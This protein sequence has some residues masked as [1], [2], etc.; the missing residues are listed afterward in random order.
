MTGLAKSMTGYGKCESV[1][2]E[3]QIVVEIKSVNNRYL[4]V[5]VK[6]PR[7]M[8]FA[9]EKIKALVGKYTTRGKIDVYIS[10][11]SK[12]ET[13]KKITVD[14]ELVNAYISAFKSA[15]EETGLSYDLSASRF[16]NNSD[17]VKVEFQQLSDE[18]IWAEFEPVISGCL[19]NYNN[20]RAVEGERLKTDILEK[21]QKVLANV[22]EIEKIVPLNIE[23]YKEKLYLK[24][25][26][27]VEAAEVDENRILSEVALYIDKIGV[28]EEIVRLKSHIETMRSVLCEEGSIGKKLDFIIQ[29]MN[30]ETNTIGSK[31]NDL[32]IT[33][34]VIEN[35]NEIEKIREQIQNIE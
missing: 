33:N 31:A 8:M 30:R 14:I 4:D 18:E 24:V 12:K 1:T 10:V 11:V 17:I 16:L 34:F 21:T 2:E 5:N 6:C 9:E 35:K 27:A 26:D 15:C 22:L 13:G 25:K 29:E 19:E 20:M 7:F 23:S 32:K 3:K 28:D